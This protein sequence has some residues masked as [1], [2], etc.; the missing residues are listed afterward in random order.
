M[1]IADL[2]PST[3]QYSITQLSKMQLIN[4]LTFFALTGYAAADCYESGLDWYNKNAA[5]AIAKAACSLTLSG[6]YG[7]ESTF[8][9]QRGSCANTPG[10][11]IDLIIK[12]IKDGNR[13]LGA[14]ECYDGLQKE[15]NGC[16]KGGHSSY[17]NWSYKYGT[18]F[19]SFRIKLV[20]ST[21]HLFGFNFSIYPHNC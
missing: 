10:G 13:Y 15:I 20:K 1:T 12:H 16:S 4:A 21:T 14:D 8:N 17:T 3:S 9:G 18:P 19:P 5:L 2:Q 6:T 11:K 7:P